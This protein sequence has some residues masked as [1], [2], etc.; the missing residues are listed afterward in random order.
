M[1]SSTE[2][3][4]PD[5]LEYLNAEDS[6]DRG[7]A[8]RYLTGIPDLR[9]EVLARI[10]ELLE[11]RTVAIIRIPIRYGEVRILAAE[12]LAS[13]RA[14]QGDPN[15]VVLENV[16]RP[17]TAER[18]APFKEGVDLQVRGAI[19]VYEALRELDRLPTKTYRIDP[20]EYRQ[21]SA[22]PDGTRYFIAGARPVK[23]V[24]TPDGGLDVQAI[25]W[26]TGAFV[27]EMSYLSRISRGDHEIDE[28]DAKHFAGEVALI[29][30][31]IAEKS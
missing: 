14:A 28:V 31:R 9:D 8:L 5:M 10:H 19:K 18:M 24:P 12:A 27:R 25:D 16:P 2:E 17:L 3:K 22:E 11:D 29:R 4:L 21:E 1:S 6:F 15:P 23:L 26:E 7:R 13:V 20:A 30:E